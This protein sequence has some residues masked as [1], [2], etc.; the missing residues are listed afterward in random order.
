MLAHRWLIGLILYANTFAANPSS[1]RSVVSPQGEIAAGGPG[2]VADYN[3][4]TSTPISR[5][6]IDPSTCTGR[7]AARLEA[8]I[9][10]AWDLAN[11]G[12]SATN[13]LVGYLHEAHRTKNYTLPPAA[14]QLNRLWLTLFG[15]SH[16]YL[17]EALGGSAHSHGQTKC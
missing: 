7:K 1:W 17:E 16:S 4:G 11:A 2:N 8:A 9:Q 13:V 6:H 15:W 5:L 12:H 10:D 3:P 14:Q